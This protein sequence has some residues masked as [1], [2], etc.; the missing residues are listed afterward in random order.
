MRKH[1][2]ASVRDTDW[3]SWPP[4]R[5]TTAEDI[6]KYGLTIRTPQ[7]EFHAEPVE[8]MLGYIRAGRPKRSTRRNAR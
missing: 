2:T 1:K 7:G 8:G 6:A 3:R 5:P 4:R